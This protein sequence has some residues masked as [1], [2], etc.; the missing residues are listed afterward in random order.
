[1]NR[2]TDPFAPGSAIAWRNCVRLSPDTAY[3]PSYASAMT[4]VHDREGELALYRG[5]GY[6]MW[7]RNAELDP[8]PAFRHQPVR[9]LLDGWSPDRDWGRWRVLVLMDPGAHHAVSLFWEDAGGALDFWYIDLIGPAE[10]RR[11]GF[12]FSEHGLDIVVQPDLSSWRWKDDDELEWNVRAGRYTRSE[13]DALYAEGER[14]VAGLRRDRARFET[15]L[16]WRPDPSWPVAMLP[17]GW[18]V[19]T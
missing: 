7:R 8:V 9:R 4:V 14:A 13:A 17:D 6:P 3:E 18:D 11:T 12:D 10:R 2:L 5:P 16:T 15:W 1:M 19:V